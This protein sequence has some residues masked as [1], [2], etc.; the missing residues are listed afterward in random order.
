M[1]AD[2]VATETSSEEPDTSPVMRRICE[3]VQQGHAFFPGAGV[4]LRRLTGQLDVYP[5][6]ARPSSAG[7]ERTI[8]RGMRPRERRCLARRATRT[9]VAAL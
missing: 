4:H 1:S 2:V 8:G 9:H 5:E 3:A 6:E 7:A